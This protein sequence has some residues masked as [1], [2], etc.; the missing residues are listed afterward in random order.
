[1]QRLTNVPPQL[2]RIAWNDVVGDEVFGIGG[3]T[4]GTRMVGIGAFIG[5]VGELL[6]IGITSMACIVGFSI[7]DTKSIDTKP[8]VTVTIL[9]VT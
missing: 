3:E 2:I 8:S 4:G 5:T 1:M 6:F 9:D 7:L